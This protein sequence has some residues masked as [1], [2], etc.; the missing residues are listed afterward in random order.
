MMIII[1]LYLSQKTYNFFTSNKYYLFYDTKLINRFRKSARKSICF[2]DPQLQVAHL[3]LLNQLRNIKA[4]NGINNNVIFGKF[5]WIV[6]Q[7]DDLVYFYKQ[8]RPNL[9]YSSQLALSELFKCEQTRFVKQNN[10]T[11]NRFYIYFI[12][13]SYEDKR[14]MQ[15]LLFGANQCV[16]YEIIEGD[17]QFQMCLMNRIY[18]HFRSLSTYEDENDFYILSNFMELL[19]ISKTKKQIITL[20]QQK[21]RTSIFNILQSYTPQETDVSANEFVKQDFDTLLVVSYHENGNFVMITLQK[22]DFQDNQVKQVSLH[23]INCD[24][25]I[26][27]SFKIFADNLYMVFYQQSQSQRQIVVFSYQLIIRDNRIQQSQ[28][29]D[30]YQ[31]IDKLHQQKFEVYSYLFQI[32]NDKYLLYQY[33]GIN[34]YIKLGA[35]G[36]IIKQF[37]G[38]IQGVGITQKQDKQILKIAFEKQL[39]DLDVQEL[40]NSDRLIQRNFDIS[41]NADLY[42]ELLIQFN[43]FMKWTKGEFYTDVA[44]EIIM[45]QFERKYLEQVIN[46]ITREILDQP[47][48]QTL[49]EQAQFEQKCITLTQW[50]KFIIQC[51]YNLQVLVNI[52]E[53]IHKCQFVA[54]L[55]YNRYHN[56]MAKYIQNLGLQVQN[57]NIIQIMFSNIFHIEQLITDFSQF[58]DID[59]IK[60]YIQI[61]ELF[62]NIDEPKNAIFWF[63][64]DEIIQYLQQLVANNIKGGMNTLLFQL[65]DDLLQSFK[66]RVKYN[67]SEEVYN[68]LSD[69][70]SIYLK[71][72]FQRAVSIIQNTQSYFILYD[73]YQKQPDPLLLDIMIS[74]FRQDVSNTELFFQY[75]IQ[76]YKSDQQR[77]IVIQELLNQ[78]TE[79]QTEIQKLFYK[80]FKTQPKLFEHYCLK[81]KQYQDLKDFISSEEPSYVNKAFSQE[82]RILAT[83]VKRLTE[84]NLQN[85]RQ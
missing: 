71:Q 5:D 75:C 27:S 8:C 58:N 31:V 46:G 14:R 3:P 40:V 69:L 9:H 42:K 29:V 76:D 12:E 78:L 18:F 59:F 83:F 81:I 50:K 85:Q 22:M 30:E 45:Q 60:L 44:L 56:L 33:D 66:R 52:N 41:H 84:A 67:Q 34:K 38:L 25:Y 43:R 73:H 37:N 47:L 54:H 7:N 6:I 17:Q 4:T 28:A 74:G 1:F 15:F 79:Q 20:L 64:Q 62:K 51:Y 55:V 80:P 72:D 11:D 70:A 39:Y 53:C 35:K 48:N 36:T 32:N 63:Q 49:D 19:I 16:I 82:G 26:I 2:S 10:R 13:R 61:L 23:K 21:L 24:T 57:P 65:F 68:K 77:T